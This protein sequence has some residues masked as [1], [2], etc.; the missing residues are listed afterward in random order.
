MSKINKLSTDKFNFRKLHP[1]IRL[2]TASDRYSGWIGQIYTP[3]KYKISSRN[4]RVGNKSF[5][6]ETLPVESVQEYFQHFTILEI[7]FTFYRP[8]LDKNL[9][10]TSNYKV[11]QSYNKYLKDSDRLILKVPQEIFAKKL[12]SLF[13]FFAIKGKWPWHVHTGIRFVEVNTSLCI[14]NAFVII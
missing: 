13:G 9:Q 2:G 7:D 3:D 8:L 6:E 5:K 11:L 10:P 14:K 4:H 12:W 1:K